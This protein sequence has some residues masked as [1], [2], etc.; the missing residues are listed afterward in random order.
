M[1]ST[2]LNAVKLTGTLGR[3]PEFKA[4]VPGSHDALTSVSIAHNTYARL[5]DGRIEKT[6]T[7][8]FRCVAWGKL[9]VDLYQN[10]S[11]GDTIQVSGK[12]ATRKYTDKDTGK[13]LTSVEIVMT[14][15]EV[16]RRKAEITPTESQTEA[17]TGTEAEVEKAA[18]VAEQPKPQGKADNA[19]KRRAKT[20][21]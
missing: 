20:Y 14:N 15:F 21:K 6:S 4:A 10:T 12:L 18:P 16:I 5:E 13:V 8:W 3:Q 7:S 19:T 1:E 11:Q 17:E 2:N 9:A